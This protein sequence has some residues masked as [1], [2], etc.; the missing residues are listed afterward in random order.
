VNTQA[1]LLVSVDAYTEFNWARDVEP[2][3]LLQQSRDARL[4]AACGNSG[5]PFLLRSFW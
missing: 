4:V 3:L 5:T 2:S 1:V